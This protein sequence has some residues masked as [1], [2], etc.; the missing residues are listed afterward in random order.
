MCVCVCVCEIKNNNFGAKNNMAKK[1][2]VW[3]PEQ[4]KVKGR[5]TGKQFLYLSKQPKINIFEIVLN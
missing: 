4:T 2:N 5:N 3:Y 1:C